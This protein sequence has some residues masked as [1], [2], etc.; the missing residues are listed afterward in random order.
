MDKHFLLGRIRILTVVS[1]SNKTLIELNIDRTLFSFGKL[2]LIWWQWLDKSCNV[3]PLIK[4]EHVRRIVFNL[5]N[6]YY[7]L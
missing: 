5:Y 6:I 3:I 2:I 4:K 1:K 7:C